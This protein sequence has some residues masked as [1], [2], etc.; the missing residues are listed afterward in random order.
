ME[1]LTIL[2]ISGAENSSIIRAFSPEARTPY[3]GARKDNY[4]ST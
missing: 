4:L 1:D 2:F 3:G